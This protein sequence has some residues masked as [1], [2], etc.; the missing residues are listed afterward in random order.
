MNPKKLIT[1]ESAITVAVET[2]IFFSIS[3]IFMGMIFLSFQGLNQKQSNLLMEEQL[4][5]IGNGIARKMTDM[6]VEA[7]M[8]NAH[9]SYT[10]LR[11]YFWIPERIVDDTYSIKFMDNIIHLESTTGKYVSVE[12][13][14]DSS[15]LLAENSTIYSNDDSH[16]IEYDSASGTFFFS[17]GGV[18]PPPN[19]YKPTISIISPAAESTID[20]ITTIIIEVGD[21]LGVTHVDY[22]VNEEWIYSSSSPYNWTWN[23]RTMEN[24]YYSVTAVAYDASGNSKPDTRNYTIFNPF[25]FPPEI[26]IISPT[27]GSSTESLRPTIKARI[28]DDREIDFSSI[29]LKVDNLTQT[30]NATFNNASSKLTTITYVPANDMSETI[31]NVTLQAKNMQSNLTLAEWLFTIIIPLPNQSSELE[32]DTTAPQIIRTGNK[33]S[34][35]AYFLNIKL[36]DNIN[37]PVQVLINGVTISWNSGGKIQSVKFDTSTFWKS[38]GSYNPSGSQDSGVPLTWASPYPAELAFKNMEIK[39]STDPVGKNFTI[40][41]ALGDGTTRTISFIASY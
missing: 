37:D 9:G 5:N 34:N 31:H 28:S 17:D 27:N 33:P 11:S 19:L 39:F 35:Y 38:T 41:F 25:S 2:I 30:A 3:I 29:I 24:G 21:D 7:R 16:G 20:N 22:F 1:D 32:I 26:T 6:I 23:T 18:I 10:S 40:V 8:S 13:P 12:V 4:M 36:K 14:V 15:I